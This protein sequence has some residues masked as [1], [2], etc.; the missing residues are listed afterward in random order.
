MRFPDKERAS[1]KPHLPIKN[2]TPINRIKT[3]ITPWPIIIRFEGG[4]QKS[5]WVFKIRQDM[6]RF[7]KYD[8]ICDE[9]GILQ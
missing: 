1:D 8:M 3:K 6:E 7:E 9:R 5:G 2:A 4:C